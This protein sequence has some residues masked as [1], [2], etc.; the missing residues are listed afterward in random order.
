[1]FNANFYLLVV[2]E[3]IR[4]I[5]GVRMYIFTEEDCVQS[6]RLIIT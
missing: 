3:W 1:M 2:Q 4:V 6:K 5:Y